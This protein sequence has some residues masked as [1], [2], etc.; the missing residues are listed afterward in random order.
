MKLS[1]E[2]Q[3]ELKKFATQIRIETVKEIGNLG[4]GHIGGSLSLAELLAV[5]YGEVMCIKPDEPKW[6]ERDRLVLSKGHAG[7]ALYA[8]LAMKGFFPMEWLLTLNKPGT[9]LPSHA[10]KNKTPGIDM[11]TG[12][13]G[14]GM[15]TACGLA[16]G[17]RM[18][19]LKNY[20]FAVIGDG[21]CDEGQVWEGALFAGHRKLN[22]LIL[23]IDYNK[24]QLDGVTDDI[25]KLGDLAAKF[26][27]FGWFSQNVDGHDVE[28][29]YE[30][31]EKAKGQKDKPS[32]IV[33]NTIK[34]QGVSFWAGS[35]NNHHVVVSKEDLEKA[36]SQLNTALAKY[37]QEG[38]HYEG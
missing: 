29:I 19:G 9:L 27:E 38:N 37:D 32:V 22:N 30:A 16:L 21:E 28:Q 2:K 11:T 12:S 4:K 5:L 6:E 15:S 17:C 8:T 35:L 1:Y 31:V 20:V 25:C 10:D 26:T 33:L 23:F 3:K 24:Q 18:K 14:Q 36:L 13:L 34:G 7:P